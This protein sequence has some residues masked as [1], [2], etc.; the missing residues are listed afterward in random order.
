LQD[1]NKNKLPNIHKK[2]I[3]KLFLLDVAWS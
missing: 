2:V 1:L 3:N